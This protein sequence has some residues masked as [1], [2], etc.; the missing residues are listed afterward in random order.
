VWGLACRPRICTCHTSNGQDLVFFGKVFDVVAPRWPGA[1]LIHTA[2]RTGAGAGRGREPAGPIFHLPR[3]SAHLFS[4]RDTSVR[5][6]IAATE[7]D[8]R[9][10]RQGFR[11]WIHDR[12]PEGTIRRRFWLP[13]E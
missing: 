8:V 12:E 7:S 11:T 1:T 10:K 3:L 2:H 13:V 4:P 5:L 9:T 6:T